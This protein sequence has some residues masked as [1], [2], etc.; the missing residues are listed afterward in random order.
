[1]VRIGGVS[2]FLQGIHLTWE[3]QDSDK[4]NSAG[5]VL[6]NGSTLY[7]SSPSDTMALL[8]RVVCCL[9]KWERKA[10]FMAAGCRVDR[11]HN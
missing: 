3:Y 2:E 9:R 6:S 11:N 8:R 4:K 10:I 7:T 5:T 1:M